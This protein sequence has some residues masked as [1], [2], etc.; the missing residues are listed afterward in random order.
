MNGTLITVT[1]TESFEDACFISVFTQL[2]TKNLWPA[3]FV[4]YCQKVT[5][6]KQEN[7]TVNSEATKVA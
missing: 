2:R 7:Y 1:E 6:R 5:K 3:R 4:H